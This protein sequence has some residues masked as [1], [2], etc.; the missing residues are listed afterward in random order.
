MKKRIFSLALV[1]LMVVSMLAFTSCNKAKPE[2]GTVT[3]MTVDINPSVEFMVDDQNKVVSVTALN[4]DGS[5]LIIGEAFIGKTPE[6]AVE[7]MVSLATE[8]G[9]LVSGNVEATENT[10]KISV[11]GD[12]KYA[13]KLQKNIEK[14]A[15]AALEKLDIN[16]KI[17][18]VEA[19]NTEALR[20]LALSTSI[21]TEEELAAMN[22]EQLYSVI[23][24]GRIE[25]ALLLT[26]DMRNAY[27][28]AKE[29]KI[30][31][32]ESE[33]VAKVIESIG[34][35]YKLTH[36][37]Y[38]SALDLYSKAIT[39]L[40][41]LRYDLL[42]SPESEYQ[43][44]LTKLREAKVEL[45]KQR[46]YT[47]SLNING[48]EY[49][50]ATVTLQLSEENYEKALSAYEE[51]GRQANAAMESLINV[52]KQAEEKLKELETT[53]FDEN[54]EEKLKEKAVEMEANVNAAK[55]SFFNEFEAA[56]ADDIKSVEDSLLAKK[57]QL[58]ASIETNA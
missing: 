6:E 5:I 9:Y 28:A 44:S 51:L 35:I 2:E 10:V 38:K 16:G 20:K 14:K 1:I 39:E 56:H 48:E 31:F 46:N 19:L 45:L 13:K 4:D 47:A 36:T 43:K 54:I 8:T 3:R 40:D 15:S 29:Y 30:S 41:E 12:T 33:E 23:A 37:A 53:L 52:L 11:S 34:G 42:V 24:M 26:E 21:Y 7:M 18:K 58:K 27:Y 50:A 57:E 55:D 49:V 22:D 25:T 32:A 17:E